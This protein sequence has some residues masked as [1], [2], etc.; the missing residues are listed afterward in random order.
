VATPREALVLFCVLLH[1]DMA[2]HSE[3][4]LDSG[5][6]KVSA[7][8]RDSWALEGQVDAERVNEFLEVQ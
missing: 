3:M 8:E 7:T 2:R 1:L 4:F 6:G 5:I